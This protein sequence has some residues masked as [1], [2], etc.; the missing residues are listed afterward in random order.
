MTLH[1]LFQPKNAKS[2]N[3]EEYSDGKVPF[4]SNS[5]LNNGVVR[6]VE[7]IADNEVITKVPCLAVNGFGFATIQ[8]EPFIGAGN[9]G[10][11]VIALI[12]KEPMT[13]LE[14]A[15]YAALINYASWR[16][17][18]GRR[19]ILRRLERVDLERFSLSPTDVRGIQ[20]DFERM[21]LGV[22]RSVFK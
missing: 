13:V 5:N 11:H 4:V 17:S 10:V 16:F 12:P 18:Y 1:S 15:Y 8:T 7:P 14:L 22:M 2:A 9:G 6:Y 19:A 3:L 20:T 21:A